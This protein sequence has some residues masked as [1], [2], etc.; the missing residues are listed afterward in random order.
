MTDQVHLSTQALVSTL[1][2]DQ[3]RRSGRSHWQPNGD[4]GRQRR[5]DR[6]AVALRP[7]EPGGTVCG[8]VEFAVDAVGA[9]AFG[10][11]VIGLGIA[12]E[13]PSLAGSTLL[14][15]SGVAIAGLGGS[16]PPVFSYKRFSEAFP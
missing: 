9:V 11:A 12:L 2:A 8:G 5:P 15:G 10:T 6:C 7:A 1:V 13:P 14:V 16:T 3:T 4:P